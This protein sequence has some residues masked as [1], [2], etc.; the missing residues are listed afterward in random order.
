MHAADLAGVM[1]VF[2]NVCKVGI[3]TFQLT[4]VLEIMKKKEGST[5][6][7]DA[8]TQEGRMLGKAAANP[9]EK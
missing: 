8:C 2:Q 6:V 5:Y 7:Y 1:V 4:C 9:P 3:C